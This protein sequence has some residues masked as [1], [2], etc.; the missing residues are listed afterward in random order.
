MT[1]NQSGSEKV[2]QTYELALKRSHVKYRGMIIDRI[3]KMYYVTHRGSLV[4]HGTNLRLV[5]ACADDYIESAY[6]RGV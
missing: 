2:L 6:R 1:K 5:M 3:K 4:K